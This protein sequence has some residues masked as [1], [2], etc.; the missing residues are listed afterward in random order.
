MYA[1]MQLSLARL[2]TDSREVES[3]IFLTL[4]AIR[5]VST[6]LILQ[7]QITRYAE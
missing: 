1:A 2:P 7:C 5:L 3:V 4:S 6:A